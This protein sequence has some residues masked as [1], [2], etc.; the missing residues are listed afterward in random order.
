MNFWPFENA[1]PFDTVLRETRGVGDSTDR[2]S[3]R[4]VEHVKGAFV[5]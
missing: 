1:C 3:G 2:E 4:F 5:A